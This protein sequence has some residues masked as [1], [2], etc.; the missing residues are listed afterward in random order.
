MQ[1]RLLLKR[2]SNF[3]SD[4]KDVYTVQSQ[5][6]TN[7]NGIISFKVPAT[8]SELNVKITF[9]KD[10]NE[11]NVR[12]IGHVKCEGKVCTFTHKITDDP[13][14]KGQKLKFNHWMRFDSEGQRQLID[15]EFNG[16]KICGE[17]DQYKDE[18][19]YEDDGPQ[20]ADIG[21]YK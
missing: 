10:V 6:G 16:E 13:L 21:G 14:T 20:C 2:L 19:E 15:F 12:N 7:Q 18:Y 9:D 11:I 1:I 4:C 3:I 17:P 5:R 8:T